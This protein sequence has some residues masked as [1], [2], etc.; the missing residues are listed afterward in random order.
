MNNK[1]LFK[2]SLVLSFLGLI[3]LSVAYV[4]IEPDFTSI[5]ELT[6]EDIGDMVTVSGIVTEINTHKNGHYFLTVKYGKPIKVVVWENI[7]NRHK[8]MGL[9]ISKTE[10]ETIEI[11]GKVEEYKGDLEI[12]AEKIKVL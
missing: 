10:G 4:K 2:I 6:E 1:T 8:L 3:V 7:A 9:D 12:I 11:I 5:S